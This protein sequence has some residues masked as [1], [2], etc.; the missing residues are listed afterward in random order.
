[1]TTKVNEHQWKS[2]KFASPAVPK[3]SEPMV[4]K[5]GFGD[6]VKAAVS[7]ENFITIG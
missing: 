3:H 1:M 5:F 6:D 4:T 7:V 2:A